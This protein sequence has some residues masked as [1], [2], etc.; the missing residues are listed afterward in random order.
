MLYSE[1]TS[2]E[3]HCSQVSDGSH[4]KVSRVYGIELHLGHLKRVFHFVHGTVNDTNGK[5]QIRRF[6]QCTL[7]LKK[8]KPAAPNPGPDLQGVEINEEVTSVSD[9]CM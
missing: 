8:W 7:L 6:G 5:P 9:Q 2:T 1:R 4:S 3:L